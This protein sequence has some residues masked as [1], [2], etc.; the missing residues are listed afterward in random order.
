[1]EQKNKVLLKNGDVIIEIEGKAMQVILVKVLSL[2]DGSRELEDIYNAFKEKDRKVVSKVLEILVKEKLVIDKE[3]C[4]NELIINNTHYD[5]INFF[6]ATQCRY[7]NEIV[8]ASTIAK[9]LDKSRIGV[10]GSSF[11]AD[12]IARMLK[13]SRVKHVKKI[14]WPIDEVEVKDVDLFI[15]APQL[16]EIY[17]L[18]EWNDYALSNSKTWMQILPY[19]GDCA[20]IGPLYLPHETVCYECYKI[21]VISNVEYK[22]ELSN[23]YRGIKNKK[24]SAR[25]Y[26]VPI[27]FD[28]LISSIASLHI[29]GSILKDE[30]KLFDCFY[31]IEFILHESE[32]KF[33]LKKN[34]IYRVPRCPKCSRLVQQSSPL[35]WSNEMK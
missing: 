26:P 23:W 25:H 10:I 28:F 5:I 12:K 13:L 3:D 9:S 18:G 29:V 35:V 32:F 17:M 33:E 8:E 20:I 2:L 34:H 24:V 6:R 1:M 30:Y 11:I 21:R 27:Q 19:D 22:E 14:S 16:K 31:T 7:E 15:L 4:N